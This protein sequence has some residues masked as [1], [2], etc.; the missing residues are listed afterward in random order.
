MEIDSNEERLY[1]LK[2][3]K[4]R[5]R[6]SQTTPNPEYEFVNGEYVKPR[7]EFGIKTLTNLHSLERKLTELKP[8]KCEIENNI[9]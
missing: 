1:L 9:K 8:V 5:I 3:I 2:L 4:D 7:S 6:V